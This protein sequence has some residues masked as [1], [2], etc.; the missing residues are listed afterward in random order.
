MNLLKFERRQIKS[1]QMKTNRRK[2]LSAVMLLYGLTKIYKLS[3]IDPTFYYIE[4]T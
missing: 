4:P 3:G 2:Q 1:I